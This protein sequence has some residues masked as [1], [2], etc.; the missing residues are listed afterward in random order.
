MR[1]AARRLLRPT[2]SLDAS[3]PGLTRQ[4]IRCGRLFAK[5]MDARVKPAHDEGEL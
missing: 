2:G 1:A 5:M 3:L 4:S